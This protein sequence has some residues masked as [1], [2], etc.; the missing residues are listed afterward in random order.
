[1]SS[2]ALSNNSLLSTKEGDQPYVLYAISNRPPSG[3]S[4]SGSSS[5][6]ANSRDPIQVICPYTGSNI[7]SGYSLRCPTSS[8]TNKHGSFGVLSLMP[9]PLNNMMG[10]GGNDINS[11]L[12]IGHGGSSGGSNNNKQQ[13]GGKDDHAFLLSRQTSSNSNNNSATNPKWKVRL[14]TTLSST[15]Q[16]IAISQNSR[17]VAA[18]ST[19]G[20]IY[21][22]DWT[23]S[24]GD[25]L[26]N[27]WKAH[28]RSITCLLFDDDNNTLFSAGEDGV[29]NAWCLL[30]LVD[31]D[32]TNTNSG[33]SSSI[34]PFQTWS[35]HHLPVTSLC[36]LPGSG[37][38]S[39]RLVSSSLDRNLIIME[40]GGSSSS[41][42]SNKDSSSNARTLARICMPSGI[43][44]VITD[45]NSHRLFSGGLD[46]NIYCIDLCKYSIQETLDGTVGGT[47]VNVNQSCGGA[48]SDVFMSQDSRGGVGGNKSGDFQSLLSGKHVL[49]SSSTGGLSVSTDQSN[50]VSELKGHVKSVTSLAL[51]DP[52]SLTTSSNF[53]SAKSTLLASGSDD[54]TLRIWDLTSRSC[55]KVLRPW[56]TSSDG[57]NI[58]TSS[59]TSTSSPPIT[60]IIAIPKSSLS[61][62]GLAISSSSGSGKRGSNGGGDLASLFKPFKSFLRGTSVVNHTS[63]DDGSVLGGISECTPILWPRRDDSKYNKFWEE[64]IQSGIS[65]DTQTKSRKR[66]KTSSNS[67]EESSAQDKVEIARLK[68]ALAES[69]EKI[70]RWQ[71]VNNQLMAKLKSTE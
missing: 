47:F 68:Q 26:I 6:G 60:S 3:S 57:M 50:Y 14:P 53:G 56:S 63:T 61:S 69:Q 24:N 48:G 36:I 51:L 34:H 31:Q 46:G 11:T 5:G 29:V 70:E 71:A 12:F 8:N 1:M 59:S 30:D 65:N 62:S 55:I 28:Y 44:T 37:C 7:T 4:S 22:W 21:L 45:I 18:S 27:V 43:Q 15:P 16:S 41:S 25:N 32:N 58:T 33:G 66:A 2:Q 54:G 23:I 42:G 20:S 39:T 9:V 35:E 40:L 10:C 38:G 52:A 49:P 13:G 64:S 67:S 17:Y 19:N